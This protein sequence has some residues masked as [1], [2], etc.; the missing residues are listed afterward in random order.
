[1]GAE[2]LQDPDK[3][4]NW[5]PREVAEAVRDK[6]DGAPE[7][8]GPWL[9]ST[10]YSSKKAT[11]KGRSGVATEKTKAGSRTE[12]PAVNIVTSANPLECLEEIEAL[13]RN[14]ESNWRYDLIWTG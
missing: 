5:Q 13:V 8:G 9:F 4:P 3:G 7:P 2:I 1:M 12:V 14:Q 11:N 10:K 6:A